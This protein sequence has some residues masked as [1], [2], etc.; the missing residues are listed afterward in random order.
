[1]TLLYVMHDYPSVSQTFVA[2]EASAVK[3]QGVPVLGYALRRGDA[4]KSA[5][6]VELICPTPGTGRLLLAA[7]RCA[8]SLVRELGRARRGGMAWREVARLGLATAH[9]AHLEGR[10][11]EAGITHVHA[12]FLARSADVADLLATRLGCRWSATAHASDVY[13]PGDPALFERR[14]DRVA[15][16]AC[17]NRGIKNRLDALPKRRSLPTHVVHCGV[18]T[19]HLS[20]L[21][22]GME[23]KPFEL[24]TVGR[25]IA[26]KGYWTILEAASH[27]MSRDPRL[28]W[29]IVGAGPLRDALAEDPRSRAIGD[30]L[31]FTGALPREEILR[32]V[33]GAAAFVLPCEVAPSGDSDGIPVAIMEAMALGVPVITT[34]VGGIPELIE[35]RDNG[36]LVE[37]QN[38]EQLIAVVEE[39][40]S[41][42]DQASL[43][44]IRRS[45]RERVA[46]E[47]DLDTEAHKLVR[48]LEPYL[49]DRAAA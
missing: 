15:V 3:A 33:G 30:R 31:H 43:D 24:V 19:A 8:P 25:L 48:I 26:T 28:R 37:P 13:V 1:M 22:E 11:R 45:G 46:T 36:F 18:E 32:V 4:E 39:I 12:H 2:L 44:A 42:M 29:T 14:L 20:T 47:F 27:L 9:A 38:A 16:V 23:R 35:S 6:E 7:A 10:C 17:A 5:A 34:A 40:L 49:T 41:K 21:G